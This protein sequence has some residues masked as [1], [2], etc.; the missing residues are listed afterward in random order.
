MSFDPFH[1]QQPPRDPAPRLDASSPNA[2][3]PNPAATF[4]AARGRV[5]FPAVLLIVVGVLNLL[6]A[7]YNVINTGF[8]LT[9]TPEQ[10]REMAV[11]Q[12]EM[13]VKA[14]PAL[15]KAFE[16][17]EKKG[18]KFEDQ[19]EKQMPLI[20]GFTIA[21]VLGTLLPLF[22][23]IRMLQLRNYGLVMFGSIVAAIPCVSGASCCCVGEVAGIYAVIMLLQSDIRDAFR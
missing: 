22:A 1:E 20:I 17:Q 9:R 16:D 21:S 8:Q 4:E 18:E 3:A 23:G 15:E 5:L 12:R 14:F 7:G 6:F 13:L 10:K 2:P 19:M 11:E